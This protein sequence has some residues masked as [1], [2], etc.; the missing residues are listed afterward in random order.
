MAGVTL[1]QHSK[2]S[3]FYAAI[4]VPIAFGDQC[5]ELKDLV[6]TVLDLKSTRSD[7]MLAMYKHI[8]FC[9]FACGIV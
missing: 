7:M 5:A 2:L 8:A 3:T 6:E 1:R 9:C 4:L